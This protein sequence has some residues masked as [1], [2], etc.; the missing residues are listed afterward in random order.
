MDDD[1][2]VVWVKAPRLDRH[3]CR[4]HSREIEIKEWL[5]ANTSAEWPECYEVHKG[6]LARKI[7]FDN[8]ADAIAA[9]VYIHSV[10]PLP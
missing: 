7:V 4:D 3:G 8:D 1:D 10:F 6:W 5:T 2:K 9:S